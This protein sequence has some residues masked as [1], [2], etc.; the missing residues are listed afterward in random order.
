M[1]SAMIQLTTGFGHAQHAGH[2]HQEK[3]RVRSL[4][5]DMKLTYL[6]EIYS[7]LNASCKHPSHVCRGMPTAV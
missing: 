7:F 2:L 1:R 5:A 3:V 4:S 6:V